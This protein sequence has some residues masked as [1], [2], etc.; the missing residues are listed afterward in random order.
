METLSFFPDMEVELVVNPLTDVPLPL[1]QTFG[2][3]RSVPPECPRCGASLMTDALP[4]VE[5]LAVCAAA[6]PTNHALGRLAKL[7]AYEHRIATRRIAVARDQLRQ[8]QALEFTRQ[9]PPPPRQQQQ[10]VVCM[11]AKYLKIL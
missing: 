2:I 5:H 7:A 11:L 10:G 6:D 1:P 9:Y 3:A 4:S 8:Q